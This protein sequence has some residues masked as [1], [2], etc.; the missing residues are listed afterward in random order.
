MVF[1]D[2]S[3]VRKH[4]VWAV[5]GSVLVGFFAFFGLAYLGLVTM[6]SDP[7]PRYTAQPREQFAK[8]IALTFDDG[9][10]PKYT[11]ELL[12]LLHDQEVPA[13]FFLIGKNVILFPEIARSIVSAGFEIGNHTF[14]HSENVGTSEERITKELLSTDHVIRDA[15]G[16]S[17][18]LFRPP[19]LEDVN[20]GEFDGAQIIGAEIRA[21]EKAGFVVVGASLDTQDWNVAPGES[22]VILARLYERISET[23]PNVIIMHDDAGE[24]ATVEALRSFIPEMRSR[25]YR[26]VFV[27]EYFGFTPSEVMPT[28]MGGAVLDSVFVGAAKSYVLG[29]S[30]FNILILIVSVLGLTRLWTMLITRRFL[31]PFWSTPSPEIAQTT[32]SALIAIPTRYGVLRALWPSAS[33]VPLPV[34]V[35]IPAYNEEANIEA[36]V[37]SVMSATT[38][39]QVIAVDDGSTD[40]TYAILLRLH[41][42][43]GPRLTVLQKENSGSKAGA[44][45]YALPYVEQEIMICIDADTIVDSDAFAYLASNFLDKRVGAVAGKVYPARMHSVFAQFQYLE[46]MQGQ[47]LE[48]SVMALGNAI[49]VVPGAIGAWRTSAVR[50]VGGYSADT[51]VE[52]QDLTY[53]LL[54]HDY[55]VLFEPR[56]LAYTETPSTFST[57]YKQRSRWVFGMIQ[58]VWKYR[59]QFFSFKHPAIGWIVLPNVAFF[60]LLI[61]ALTPLI[62]GILILGLFGFV[63]IRVALMP[64]IIYTGFDL[65]CALEGIAQEKNASVRLI[66]LVLWQR[67]FYRYVIALAVYRGL[68]H[69]LSGT[70]VGWGAQTRRGDC[71]VALQDVFGTLS[72]ESP[73]RAALPRQPQTI[74][75]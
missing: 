72:T 57:F 8:T 43:Y 51:V 56:A 11:P 23:E 48:K 54:A 40:A 45:N 52:D 53:A 32:K 44:L 50:E 25:G 61:P 62:D 59:A 39:S 22:D 69:A 17:P 71:H 64:F 20:V 2:V 47:N 73:I 4:I 36:T 14:T 12:T 66:P 42:Q 37:L 6:T 55:T 3:G 19:Y 1:Y 18:R 16:L 29:S 28:A 65:W 74:G 49:S 31:V 70:F 68:I 75:S 15:T 7:M 10:H 67:F 26:F 33:E 13:T 34:T 41:K 24:G 60:N 35:I 58:C 27:S 63:D 5:A 30:A 21:A 38:V 46:Y 9:P